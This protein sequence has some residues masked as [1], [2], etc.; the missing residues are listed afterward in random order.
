M[1]DCGSRAEC[2]C[3]EEFFKGKKK[4][5]SLKVCRAWFEKSYS[6][7]LIPTR[8]M[9]E[10]IGCADETINGLADRFG[11]ERRPRLPRS[12][13][14]PKRDIDMKEVARLYFD[15]MMPCDKI[16]EIFGM[17]GA[18]I[19]KK[20]RAA[21]Y[22]LRHHNDTKR[23]KPSPNK[24]YIDPEII[25]ELY[26]KRYESGKTIADRFGV[27][28]QV[29]HRILNEQGVPRKPV[30]DSHDMSGENHPRWRHDLTDEEREN[31]RDMAAQKRW[32]EQI[33]ERDGYTCQACS[34][35]SGGNLNAH[36]IVPHS[37]DKSI[38]WEIY[39]GLTMCKSCHISF[40][41][42]YGY[43]ACTAEDLAEFM[44]EVKPNSTK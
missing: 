39:N 33:F 31:R 28:R 43:T 23:G 38:A 41:M 3:G 40:H 18:S 12:I 20:L 8:I 16:G 6:S 17:H 37:K 29:I 24:I 30:E 11:I 32:R 26:A 2:D 44:Q 35:S 14:Y 22:K 21:G 36:H 1:V 5:K 27:S 13:P 19:G 7:D 25:I 9:A 15:E 34:D 10:E 42:Q 4:P